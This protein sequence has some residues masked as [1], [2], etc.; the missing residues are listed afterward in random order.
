M[1]M[2]ENNIWNCSILELVSVVVVVVPLCLQPGGFLY[3]DVPS[4]DFNPN[5][6]PKLLGVATAIAIEM[7]ET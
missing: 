7:M 4:I 6:N 2:K 3:E 1:A 5:Y